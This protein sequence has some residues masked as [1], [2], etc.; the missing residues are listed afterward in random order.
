MT[1]WYITYQPF[2]DHYREGTQFVET[3]TDGFAFQELTQQQAAIVHQK[4][5]LEKQRKL[6]AKRK[7][8]ST[9]SGQEKTFTVYAVLTYNMLGKSK[10]GKQSPTQDIEGFVKPQMPRSVF[11]I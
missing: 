4:E 5:E 9:T 11:I 3:W 6:L 1:E 8:T 10:G 2:Y 7:T